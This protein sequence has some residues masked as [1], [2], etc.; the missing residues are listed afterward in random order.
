[1]F[2]TFSFINLLANPSW[3]NEASIHYRVTWGSPNLNEYA[4]K[5]FEIKKNDTASILVFSSHNILLLDQQGNIN[6]NVP[7]AHYSMRFR[8]G[9]RLTEELFLALYSSED[10]NKNI[11]QLI[12]FNTDKFM[13]QKSITLPE[14]F[15]SAKIIDDYNGNYFILGNNSHRKTRLY[16]MNSQLAR[17][18]HLLSRSHQAL[19]DGTT[20]VDGFLNKK[21]KA[22]LLV[23]TLDSEPDAYFHKIPINNPQ[24]SVTQKK[25]RLPNAHITSTN[26]LPNIKATFLNGKLVLLTDTQSNPSHSTQQQLIFFNDKYVPEKSIRLLNSARFGSDLSISS[27]NTLMVACESKGGH[28][29][30][31]EI[32]EHGETT[33]EWISI[34]E[35]QWSPATTVIKTES[36]YIAALETAFSKKHQNKGTRGISLIKL[37]KRP[38]EISVANKE[39]QLSKTERNNSHLF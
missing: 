13:T 12:L 32:N 29:M 11:S 28:G 33:F 27:N 1:M 4:G 37:T 3:S 14:I 17:V 30:I 5:I 25:L 8:D 24:K 20:L 21:K 34:N 22:L 39:A 6:K 7:A 2:I 36:G 9:I 19:L 23:T 16:V 10:A 26:G 31:A 15:T 35:K 18:E 38:A